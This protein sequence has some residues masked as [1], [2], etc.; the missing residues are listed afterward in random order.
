M[1]RVLPREGALPEEFIG[2]RPGAITL[3]R[4]LSAFSFQL[5][6]AE[7]NIDI[8]QLECIFILS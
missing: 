2:G 1:G 5:F 8:G 3:S 7:F 6:N 4:Q